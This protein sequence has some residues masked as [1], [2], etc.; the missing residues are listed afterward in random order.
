MTEALWPYTGAL[1]IREGFGEDVEVCAILGLKL[2]YA[3]PPF[4]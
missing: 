3:L 1:G 2:E 4:E